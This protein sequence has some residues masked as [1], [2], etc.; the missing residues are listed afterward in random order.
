VPILLIKSA[1]ASF[2]GVARNNVAEFAVN[3]GQ[4]NQ[5]LNLCYASEQQSCAGATRP[6]FINT[7]GT[8]S[9]SWAAPNDGNYR[10]DSGH[11][12]SA[13]LLLGALQTF[14][15]GAEKGDF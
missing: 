9:P 5:P 14:S 10:V 12:R 1:V 4:R 8:F 3:V 6:D 15:K 7:I 2:D 11:L 13:L